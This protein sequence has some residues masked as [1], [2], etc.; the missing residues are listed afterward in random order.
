MKERRKKITKKR[1]SS[2]IY[3][4]IHFIVLRVVQVL[5]TFTIHG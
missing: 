1:K 4:I 5:S 2:V 3:S